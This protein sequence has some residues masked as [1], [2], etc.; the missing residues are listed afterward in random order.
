MKNL[1]TILCFSLYLS[2]CSSSSHMG[3]NIYTEDLAPVAVSEKK[4]SISSANQAA[5]IASTNSNSELTDQAFKG[6]PTKFTT[7]KP[8]FSSK[9]NSYDKTPEEIMNSGDF[10]LAKHKEISTEPYYITDPQHIDPLSVKPQKELK[11]WNP[12]APQESFSN[13]NRAR[14]K[15]LGL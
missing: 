11:N 2:G 15:A 9:S 13:I 5:K 12:L 6:R 8:V 7:K 14:N 3:S 10:E 1:L 4:P